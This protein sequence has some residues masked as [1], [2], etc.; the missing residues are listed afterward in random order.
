MNKFDLLS[1]YSE[2]NM[3]FFLMYYLKQKGLKMSKK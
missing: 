1:E 2:I 3:F